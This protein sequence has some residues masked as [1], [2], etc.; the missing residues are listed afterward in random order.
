MPLSRMRMR[1]LPPF[2]ISIS[3]R[4]ALAS[5]LFSM[6]SLMI[7]AGRSMTSP[8][9]ILEMV[10]LSSKLMVGMAF[11]LVRRGDMG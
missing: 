2:S 3:M 7:E 8:A 4:V 9:A 6:S 11:I 1:V 5:R 10:A